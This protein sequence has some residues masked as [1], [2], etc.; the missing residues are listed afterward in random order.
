MSHTATRTQAS[1]RPRGNS[2]ADAQTERLDSER[3]FDRLEQAV[4]ALVDGYQQALARTEEL[5]AEID[6]KNQRI[7]QLETKVL[8][9]NQRRQDVTK[10][11]DELIAQLDQLDAQLAVSSEESAAGSKTDRSV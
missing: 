4:A 1:Q 11:I 10:R 6:E 2:G 8:D 7:R 9:V 5:R 3:G